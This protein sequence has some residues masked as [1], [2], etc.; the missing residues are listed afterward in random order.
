MIQPTLTLNFARTGQLGRRVNFS[1]SSTGVYTGYDGILKYAGINEP[2]F[3]YDASGNSLGL[4]I[5]E[6]RT[7]LAKYSQDFEN[8]N[9]IK[10]N[11]GTG[12]APIITAN[13]AIAP[14]G[15]MTCTRI[16]ADRGA[17]NTLGD[18]SL[19]NLTPVYGLPNPHPITVSIW[20]KSTD[21]VSTQEI[22]FSNVTSATGV[23]ITVTGELQ[24]F[25]LSA[26]SVGVDND[27]LKIGSRGTINSTAS[28]DILVWG[29][30][31]E[32][33]ATPSSYIPTT[34][35][36]VTRTADSAEISG[37]PFDSWIHTEGTLLAKYKN[38]GWL[39]NNTPPTDSLD[40][41]KY[42]DDYS[43]TAAGDTI[44]R[45]IF[46]PRTLTAAQRG[47]IML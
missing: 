9:W 15:T 18:Y 14:D 16:Q 1:R 8:A 28:V 41:A 5:E 25:S 43:T 35:A 10:T 4:L 19:V 22:N 20:A 3:D 29:A 21:G 13:Q 33:A 36:A 32:A 23:S 39:Y 47:R 46:Y 31:L 2:R 37:D 40:L 26:G 38:A 27:A 44:E 6:Q 34:S 24:R 45:I 12:S 30:Q 7:N 17:G 11:D 42:I